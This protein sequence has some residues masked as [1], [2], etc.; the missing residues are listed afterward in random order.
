METYSAL[1][2]ICVGNSPVISELPAQRPVTWRFDVFFDLH[3]IKWLSKQLPG[4]WFETLSH[5]LWHHCNG[6]H[7]TSE[8]WILHFH[9]AFS[10]HKALIIVYH[11]NLPYISLGNWWA[12]LASC[13]L[14][15]CIAVLGKCSD[16]CMC[17]DNEQW[18]YIV[19]SSPIG[20]VHTQNDPWK[21]KYG[22]FVKKYIL[23][24]LQNCNVNMTVTVFHPDA[25]HSSCLSSSWSGQ[26]HSQK[27]GPYY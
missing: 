6:R 14:L 16:H 2:A 20:W 26:G 5:P 8:W 10:S 17:L 11:I 1:L 15:V 19:A 12:D 3:K 25:V 9:W 13:L 4:W 18:R 21:W 27:W 22:N 7:K 23:L 24:Y